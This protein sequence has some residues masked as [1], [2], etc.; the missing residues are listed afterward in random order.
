MGKEVS[1]ENQISLAKQCVRRL[2]E[3][4]KDEIFSVVKCYQDIG[5]TGR[6]FQREGFWELLGDIKDGKINCVIVKDLSRFGRN[7]LET[8][9]YIEKI[10]PLAGV[11][12]IAVDGY[13]TEKAGNE[14]RQM[15]FEIQNLINELYAKEFSEKAKLSIQKRRDRGSYVGGPPP[16]GF[17]VSWQGKKRLLV[18]DEKVFWVV[19]MILKNYEK[20]NSYAAVTRLLNEKKINPPAQ[21]RKSQQVFVSCNEGKETAGTELPVWR[22]SAVERI[23]KAGRGEIYETSGNVSTS[24]CRR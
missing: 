18:R 24:V 7:Y 20:T 3:E 12:F 1:I 10:F 6:T 9:R 2:N 14:N 11:R 4:Q 16:Y 5:K 23:V 15:L 22:K 21:Y 13:D 17:Q 8:G 19:E